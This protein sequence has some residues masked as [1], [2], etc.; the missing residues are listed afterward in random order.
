MKSI[1]LFLLGVRSGEPAKTTKPLMG[2]S[3]FI[4]ERAGLAALI[5]ERGAA[6]KKESI[7]LP[8][9]LFPEKFIQTSLLN[10]SVNNK[11]PDGAFLFDC[12]ES[13][14]RTRGTL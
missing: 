9:W 7:A 6:I 3:C 10:S 8:C 13:G 11:A 1:D 2:L 4:A 14:I 5:P 12:G